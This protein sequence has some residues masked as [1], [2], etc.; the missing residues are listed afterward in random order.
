MT[1]VLDLP[2]SEEAQA[3]RRDQYILDSA[4]HG[5]AMSGDG[6]KLCVAGTVSNYAAIV[7][8]DDLEY[9]I[10]PLGARTYWATTSRGGGECYVSVAGDNTVSIISYE[11]E[12]EIA[13]VPVGEHPSRVRN[14]RVDAS[15]L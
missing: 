7:D 6:S 11:T 13:R 14:G 9:R 2:L 4:H 3:M 10:H 5:I 12:Q 1:R 8:V 15:L